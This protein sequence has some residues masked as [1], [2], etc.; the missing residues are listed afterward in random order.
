MNVDIGDGAMVEVGDITGN[1]FA[2]AINQSVQLQLLNSTLSLADFAGPEPESD[3]QPSLGADPQL[4]DPDLG[5]D[6]WWLHL[7]GEGPKRPGSG[8]KMKQRALSA[9]GIFRYTK[10]GE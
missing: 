5:D 10:E 1:D 8:E 7:R 4:L 6:M 9:F 3:P 2:D